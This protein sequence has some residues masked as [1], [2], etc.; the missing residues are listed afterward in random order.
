M[1]SA[2]TIPHR[3]IVILRARSAADGCVGFCW[4]PGGPRAGS[5]ST[6]VWDTLLMFG[7]CKN[8]V[9]VFFQLVN[10]WWEK[11]VKYLFLNT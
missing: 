11:A 9:D 1:Q 3:K 5:G 7:G 6:G 8:E 4:A 10:V 2:D